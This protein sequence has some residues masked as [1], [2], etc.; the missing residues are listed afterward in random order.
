MR[1]GDGFVINLFGFANVNDVRERVFAT[2]HPG[3]M[4]F[5]AADDDWYVISWREDD[6][7]LRR[8]SSRIDDCHGAFGVLDC[9]PRHGVED[10]RYAAADVPG[11]LGARAYSRQSETPIARAPDSLCLMG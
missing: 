8:R 6:H 10:Y 7:H 9:K 11:G 1:I 4:T 3:K 5:T 2:K